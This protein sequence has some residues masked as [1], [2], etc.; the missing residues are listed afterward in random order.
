MPDMLR[1]RFWF[2]S[3][4]ALA[5][6]ALLALTA[7]WPDWIERIV[8]VEPD[9]GDGSLEWGLAL[10]LVLLTIAASSVAGLEWRRARRP[11]L[12]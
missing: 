6:A 10:A 4:L 5:S 2:E 9:G 12:G 11:A 8:G 1:T 3:A 7:A